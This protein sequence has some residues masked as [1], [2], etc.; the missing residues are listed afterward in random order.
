MF[1]IYVS[2]IRDLGFRLRDLGFRPEDSGF[3]I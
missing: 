3:R 1:G 2:R